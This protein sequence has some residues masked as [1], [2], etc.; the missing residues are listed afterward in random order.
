MTTPATQT[1]PHTHFF[2]DCGHDAQQCDSACRAESHLCS[3]CGKSRQ[4]AAKNVA[5]VR[6]HIETSVKDI[7]DSLG[8]LTYLL[9][10][11]EAVEVIAR[12]SKELDWLS[13]EQLVEMAVGNERLT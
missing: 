10:L 5:E 4:E 3:K 8:G 12:C 13:R 11:K 9:T 1:R 7:T 2:M 6:A